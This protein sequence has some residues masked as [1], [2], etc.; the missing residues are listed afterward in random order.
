MSD[1]LF[2]L[3]SHLTQPQR[4]VVA[5]VAAASEETGEQCFLAGGAMR[6]MLGGFPISDL[7]F[8]VQGNAQT[9]ARLVA[10]KG[11]AR[12]VESDSLRKS[13]DL[14]FPSGVTAEI[15]L[16]RV[17]KY[18]KPGGRPKVTP[19]T[20]HEDL[21]RRDF[22]MNS[23]ALSLHPA[24]RGLL[25]DPTNGHADI[26]RGELRAFSSQ[27][28]H[29]DPVRM[30]RLIRFRV[31]FDFEID[32]R[33]RAR[34]ES[35]REAGVEQRIPPRTLFAELRGISNETRIGEILS[36]LD[37]EGLL[38]LFSPSLAG[39]KLNLGMLGKL[40]K[41]RQ[42]IPHGASLRLDNLGLFLYFLTEKLSPREKSDLVKGLSMKPEES[43]L[44][45]KLERRSR[46]L[47][48]DLKSPK[49][50]RSSHV[51]LRLIDAPGDEILFLYLHSKERLVHDRI[52]NFLQKH[53]YTALEVTDR[54]V[55]LLAQIN[56][57]HDDFQAVKREII[58][59]R[60][61]NRNWKSEILPEPEPEPP[62]VTARA[63]RAKKK[64]AKKATEKSAPTKKAPAK[65]AKKV[66]AKKSPAKKTPI[67]KTPVKKAPAKKATA[68]KASKRRR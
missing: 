21:L 36:A 64:S 5:A 34:Y 61:D 45:Q 30:L 58:V 40:E 51:Y 23:I 33:T 19:A 9:V 53:L 41:A 26:E 63:V 54:E 55:C 62:P 56:P 15:A 43:E 29:D 48:K 37:S 44:W 10:K 38:T 31:R 13:Y 67:K 16:A 27:A 24:S 49:L 6:D 35:A 4:D 11:R 7:D 47:E 42:M 2:M 32:E 14:V 25:L 12:I 20:I 18:P 46:K 39:S 3:E 65:A 60:L 28:F 57:T 17:E 68:K 8:S 59:A 1:Y 66:T 22:T 52:K 50:H